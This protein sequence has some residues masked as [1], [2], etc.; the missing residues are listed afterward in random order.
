MVGDV[1]EIRAR[2]TLVRTN[3]DIY[4]IVPNA[5]FITDTVTNWSY[6]TPRVSFH[7]PVS[8]AYGANRAEA[9]RGT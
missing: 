4:L 7:F 2:A 5:R 9:L 6:R 1:A 3:D 8:V